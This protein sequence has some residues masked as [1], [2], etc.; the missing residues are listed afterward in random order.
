MN[1]VLD[2]KQAWFLQTHKDCFYDFK[3]SFSAQVLQQFWLLPRPYFGLVTH[4]L[5][6]LKF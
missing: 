5:S 1:T 6:A 3:V 4:I 2:I